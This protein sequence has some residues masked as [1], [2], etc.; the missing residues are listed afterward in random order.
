MSLKGAMLSVPAAE[1]LP[2]FLGFL[3]AVRVV[4]CVAAVAGMSEEPGPSHRKR[5]ANRFGSI[6]GAV[7]SV[8]LSFGDLK[9]LGQRR[10]A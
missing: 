4:V 6:A 3:G 7:R 2:D 8:Q 10:G 1:S 5:P 9:S